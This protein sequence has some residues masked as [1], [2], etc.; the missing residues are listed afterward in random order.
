[1]TRVHG[2][3]FFA[4]LTTLSPWLHAGESVVHAVLFYSPTCPH[5]H[6]VIAEHLI[7]M[8]EKYGERLLGIINPKPP[9]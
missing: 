4:L 9:G 7:P 3:L 6:K 5:C 8:E 2:L 1:M